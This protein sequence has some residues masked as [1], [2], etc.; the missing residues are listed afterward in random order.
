MSL[1]PVQRLT[2]TA[3]LLV[4]GAGL[5]LLVGQRSGSFLGGLGMRGI[6]FGKGLTIAGPSNDDLQANFVRGDFTVPIG[7]L[8]DEHFVRISVVIEMEDEEGRAELANL[9][10][11]LR[12]AFIS[13]VVDSRPNQFEGQAGLNRS[14]HLLR[15]AVRETAPFLN[16]RGIYFSELFVQ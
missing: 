11:R 8:E 13:R 7:R 12:D 3:G 6:V 10:P 1:S 14:R 15:E 2:A 5:A 4:L 16:V 9:T